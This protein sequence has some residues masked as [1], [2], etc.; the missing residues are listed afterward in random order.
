M[1]RDEGTGRKGL[2]IDIF[3]SQFYEPNSCISP[4]LQEGMATQSSIL[5]WII[6]WTEELGGLV[7]GVAE[8]TQLSN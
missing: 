8:Q 1:R 5:A 7:H 4:Y 2:H 3:R 6:P